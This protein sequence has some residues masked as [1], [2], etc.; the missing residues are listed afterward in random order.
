MT[1]WGHQLPL[2][3]QV[4]AFAAGCYEAALKPNL[5]HGDAQ[6]WRSVAKLH[7][8][9]GSEDMKVEET[10]HLSSYQQPRIKLEGRQ[11]QIEIRSY[12]D[13]WYCTHMDLHIVQRA[14]NYNSDG[15]ETETLHFA[16]RPREEWSYDLG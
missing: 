7:M 11:Q 1:M 16:Q 2:R 10:S 4:E 15:E 14:Q 5:V 13:W 6:M 12:F 8:R 3:R 9:I